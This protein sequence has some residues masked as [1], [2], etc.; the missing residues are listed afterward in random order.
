MLFT[1]NKM[2]KLGEQ[3]NRFYRVEKLQ[4]TVWVPSQASLEKVSNWSPRLICLNSP[5]RTN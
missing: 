2:S 5:G 1:A 4:I 3:F